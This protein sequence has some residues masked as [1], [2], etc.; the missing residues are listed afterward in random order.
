MLN[1]SKIPAVL[2]LAFFWLACIGVVLTP[3]VN[4]AST[5]AGRDSTNGH[6]SAHPTDTTSSAVPRVLPPDTTN[7]M[8]SENAPTPENK[9]LEGLPQTGTLPGSPTTPIAPGVS[10]G[11]GSS[12]GSGMPG[13]R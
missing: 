1:R 11:G 13:T 12:G 9:P 6:T 7:L 5:L 3:M 8:P 4:A 10:P 2:Y